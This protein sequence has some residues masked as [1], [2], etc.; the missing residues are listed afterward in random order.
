LEDDVG[1]DISSAS[2]RPVNEPPTPTMWSLSD[3]RV[4]FSIV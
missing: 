1:V 3:S 2:W 4:P